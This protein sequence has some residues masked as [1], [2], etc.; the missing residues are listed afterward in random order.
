MDAAV[1]DAVGQVVGQEV[2][3]RVQWPCATSTSIAVGHGVCPASRHA[4]L[5]QLVGIDAVRAEELSRLALQQ[6]KSHMLPA[7]LPL[8][9]RRQASC[10]VSRLT[11]ATAD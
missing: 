11:A 9:V 4:T 10:S 5:L 7:V 8:T 1:V 6:G 2:I 3:A